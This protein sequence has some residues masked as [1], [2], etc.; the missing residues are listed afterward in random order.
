MET[1]SNKQSALWFLTLCYTMALVFS[2]WFGPRIVQIFSVTTGGGIIIFPLTFL[3]SDL[4]TEVYGYK[5]A[6]RA[7]WYG[8]LFN[9]IFLI[10]GQIVIHLPSPSFATQNSNFDALFS[11]NARM[12]IAS[13]ISYFIAEPL[14]SY[15]LS[16]LK[17]LTNGKYL[18]VRFVFSTLVSSSLDSAIFSMIA[19]Y[20]VFSN[21]DLLVLAVSMWLLK[22]AIEILGLPLSM[23]LVSYLKKREQVD[24]YDRST[25]FNLFK[26]ETAYPE[27]ANEFIK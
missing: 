7:I 6:R 16:K 25:N 18:S 12:V 20:G 15:L 9:I 3:L 14:N 23:W 5:N 19:F 26:I 11:A 21:K 4:I 10:Y 17:I 13:L 2:N 27:K 22:T 8:F 1:S 24:I